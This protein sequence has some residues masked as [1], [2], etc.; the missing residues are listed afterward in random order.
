MKKVV[1]YILLRNDVGD[2]QPFLAI[3]TRHPISKGHNS[4]GTQHI[5]RRMIMTFLLKTFDWVRVDVVQASTRGV[6]G[7]G[8]GLYCIARCMYNLKRIASNWNRTDKR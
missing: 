3:V 5:E 8:P 1:L 2:A 7:D 4:I 6:R